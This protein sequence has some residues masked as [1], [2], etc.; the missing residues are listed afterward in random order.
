MRRIR[1][2]I[3]VIGCVFFSQFIFAQEEPQ[4]VIFEIKATKPKF[5]PSIIRVKKDN[6]VVLKF[7]S[8]DTHHGITL[9]DF[10]LKEVLLP[11]GEEATVEFMAD[12][13]GTF[14][15][16]CTKFCGWRHLVFRQGKLKIIV[17]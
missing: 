15:F 11:K 10:G 8:T 6:K 9:S 3:F 17:E 7:T 12:K 16:P 5:E 13:I 14:T 2:L 1:I 4:T